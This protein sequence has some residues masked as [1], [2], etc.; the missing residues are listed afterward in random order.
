MTFPTLKCA[1]KGERERPLLETDAPNRLACPQV[2]F[3]GNDFQMSK[4]T[5][6][7]HSELH[8][9][10]LQLQMERASRQKAEADLKPAEAAI[11]TLQTSET[12]FRHLTEYPLALI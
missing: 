6:T 12:Y 8:R 5:N 4:T 9:L 7:S 2:S 11:A 1:K 10:R 3:A